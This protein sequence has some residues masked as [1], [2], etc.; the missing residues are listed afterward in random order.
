MIILRNKD[1]SRHTPKNLEKYTEY[2]D[3]DLDKMTKG[4]KLRAREEEDEKAERNTKK[5]IYKKFKKYIPIG[6]ASGAA[7]GL[8]APKGAKG[9][10]ALQGGLVGGVLGA[11]GGAWRGSSKAKKEGHDRD[12]RSIALA[13]RIDERARA[14][15][16]DDD[17][18]E[19]RVKDKIR[20]RRTE[21]TARRAEINSAMAMYNTW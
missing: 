11:A 6:A 19:Y 8:L 14:N 1:F 7:L 20:Q 16:R 17:D 18:Y 3:E 9:I 2:T 12:D 10:V 15:G 5:Y 4:Q 13:R 21:E